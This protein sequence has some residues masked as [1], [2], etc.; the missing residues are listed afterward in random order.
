MLPGF[1]E[2]NNIQEE[3]VES[4]ALLMDLMKNGN[5]DIIQLDNHGQY[6]FAG[7]LTNIREFQT[8]LYALDP[9]YHENLQSELS[10]LIELYESVFEHKQ[11]TG[12][13]GT[14]FAYEGIGSIYWHMV[15]K[16]RYAVQECLINAIEHQKHDD[17][18]NRL[19]NHYVEI[20]KGIGVHKSPRHYGAF[21]T[22]PYSHTPF[23]KGAQQPGMTGQVKEDV[24]CR[25]RELG[26]NYSNGA[27]HFNSTMISAHDFISTDESILFSDIHGEKRTVFIPS[28]SL[29][30]TICQTPIL[31]T[32]GEKSEIMIY[33]NDDSVETYQSN[34]LSVSHSQRILS[35]DGSIKQVQVTLEKIGICQ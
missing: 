5:Q 25:M 2:K 20:C 21:P 32:L 8:A 12:R 30:I 1:L 26:V 34:S 16:L 28:G 9:T 4:S 18:I 15:S 23:G 27:I 10:S 17:I 35:R 22:D 6:H 29:F 31:L 33:K 13:S 3:K 11:F 19:R 24:I 7:E 14:F